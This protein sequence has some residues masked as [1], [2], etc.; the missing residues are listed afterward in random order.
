MRMFTIAALVVLMTG[1]AGAQQVQLLENDV[2][3]SGKA[4]AAP[5]EDMPQIIMP[6]EDK[7]AAAP[8]PAGEVK[9]PDQAAVKKAVK[10]VAK[11]MTA[12]VKA[13]AATNNFPSLEEIPAASKPAQEVKSSVQ[14]KPVEMAKPAPAVAIKPAVKKKPV[15]TPIPPAEPKPEGGFNVT[16]VHNVVKGDT[17]WDLSDKY[18]NDPY[19]WGRIYNANLNVVTN[20]D[21]IN[22]KEELI[23]PEIMETVKPE[24]EKA[25]VIG[26]G[27]T[28]KDAD[29]TSAEVTQ[30]E[31]A[32]AP[33]APVK[34]AAAELSEALDRF[35]RVDLSED[36]PEHQKEWAA[37]V[38]IVPDDWREDGV[39]TAKEKGDDDSMENS[40][41][42]S[43]DTMTI[44]MARSDL[45]KKGDRLAVY[46]KGADAYDKHGKRLG[47]EVQAAG[48]LEVL[49]ADGSSVRA[50]VMDSVT[51]IYKGYVVKKK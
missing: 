5:S 2:A 1:W 51:P 40:L 42:M 48:T 20:P 3:K 26:E 10:P 47:R 25:L 9:K 16:K 32:A 35:D 24:P 45:V 17:L 8:K 14:A 4:A 37:G 36:M 12:E 27:D 49:E 46:M 31:A 18:Y 50:M 6:S 7:P 22:P 30:P 33:A 41:S 15:P 13:P 21:L 23:I 11:E 38:K 39:I 29:L 28:V 34:T 19:K 43:G 44:F